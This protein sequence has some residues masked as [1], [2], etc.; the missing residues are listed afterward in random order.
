MP[1]PPPKLDPIRRHART[2]PVKLPAEGRTGDVPEWPL[3]GRTTAIERDAW[4]Q[5][6]RTPQAV[7]WEKLG[8]TRTVA[9]YCRVMVE[10]ERPKAAMT[11][12]AEARNLEDRL[13]LTPKA[14]RM[15]L[16][17]VVSDEVAEKRQEPSDARSRIKAV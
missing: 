15:L 13:G 3:P 14:M 6:W 2:G 17:E 5:L 1:G 8:W 7:V 10:A 11:A 12:R 9:R 4:A 16:W